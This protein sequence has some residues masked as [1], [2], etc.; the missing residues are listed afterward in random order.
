M[1]VIGCDL[2]IIGGGPGGLSVAAG[3]AQM[4]ARVVLIEAAAMGGDCLNAG[5]VPSKALLAA[6]DA[7]AAVRRAAAFGVHAGAPDIDGAAV[8]AHVRDVI[9]A[10][11]PHD[12]VE[13]F[14]GLGVTVIRARARFASAR[15]V[16]AGEARV[17]ARRFVIATGSRPA[18][19]PIPGLAQVPFLTNETLF[20]LER[21]PQHLLII[22]GGPV[23]VE[24]ACAFRRLGAAVSLFEQEALLPREDAA[25]VAV[26]RAALQREGVALHEGAAVQAVTGDAA[27]T[28]R[29]RV[30]GQAGPV[31]GSGLLIATGRRA[32]VHDLGLD[33][34]GVRADDRGIIV[35]R[36]LRT[37]NRRVFAIGD[38]VGAVEGSG[39]EWAAGGRF[40]HVAGHHADIVLRRALFRLPAR[41]STRAVPRVTYAD[42]ELAQVGLTEAEARARDRPVRVLTAS[43][44]ENDRARAERA[45]EG[46]IKV[47]TTGRGR[48]LGA[49][50]AG[51]GAGEL[52]LP[53]TLAI[54]RGLTVGSLAGVIVPYPTMSEASKRAAGRFFEPFLFG[55]G[56][57]RLAR[58]LSRLG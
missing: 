42:P 55:P 34:A 21:I 51:R 44:A 35:D 26:L 45:T 27:G 3:A 4:G 57:R 36:G 16:V 33:A 13:R 5:C 15:E 1:S 48:I 41:I 28:V 6:A 31:S 12:S 24:M 14:E 2:C 47:V 40:T 7:A 32:S 29:L 22:G 37:S 8:F 53:W 39:G 54:A 52:I 9:A 20:G 46:L 11:A 30:S 58:L 43:F 19:P 17:R 38:V 10:I 25:L 18:I 56:V 23:G 49:G 50:I